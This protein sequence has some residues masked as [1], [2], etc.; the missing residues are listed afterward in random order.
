[1]QVL[2]S[3]KLRLASEPSGEES[4]FS[5]SILQAAPVAGKGWIKRGLGTRWEVLEKLWKLKSPGENCE[6]KDGSNKAVVSDA[7][8]ISGSLLVGLQE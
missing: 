7:G 3:G 1:M 8:G 5:F 6:A 4:M 2:L